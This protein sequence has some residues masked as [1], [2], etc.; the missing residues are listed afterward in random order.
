MRQSISLAILLFLILAVAPVH[1]WFNG[2]H[3]VVACIAYKNLTPQTQ[4]RV[5]AL[6]KKNPMYKTWTKG[7]AKKDKGL[8]AFVMAATWADCIKDHICAPGYTSDGGDVPPGKPTDDQNIGYADKLMHR[9]WHFIDVPLSA[10]APGLPPKFPNAQTEILLLTTAIGSNKSDD[11][12]SYDVVW[13]EHLVGDV[14]QPLHAT[15]RFTKNHSSGDRGGN[16]VHFCTSPCTDE[17]HAFWDGQLGDKP[18]VAEVTQ[19][20]AALIA[21]G[22]P[23][24]ADNL[25]PAS[26]VSDSFALSAVDVYVAPISD[27]NDPSVTISPRPDAAYQAKA[28]TVA[29]AQVALA[30]FRLAGLLNQNLK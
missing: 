3:M 10:G 5:D 18:T 15:S 2:G 25:D 13:L 9:Y 12:K 29:R 23:A 14:H 1:A 22:K 11:I 4:A 24:G 20:A 27:D 19:T 28:T 17:L 21:L 8:T 6:L 30:G 26:W 7:I 16:S